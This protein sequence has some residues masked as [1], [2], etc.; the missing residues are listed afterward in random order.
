VFG[1]P[2]FGKGLVQTVYPL[3]EGTGLALTTALYY[4]PSGRSIQKP[5]DA[6]Q[7]ELAATT[8]HPNGSKEFRTDKGRPVLGG[9]GIQ[10]D[11]VVYPPQMNRL[12]TVLE[13]T[14]S[15]TSFA[16]EYL[17]QHKVTDEFEVTPQVIDEFQLW[18]SERAIQ[19]GVGEWSAEREFVENR[20]KTEIFNQ[21]LGVEKGD[22]VEA[23]RDPVIR[24][25]VEALGG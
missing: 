10:P 12:R 22:Q 7:F 2:S 21:A 9:G 11:V 23:E 5:L 15:F 25:A 16:T 18:L 4:T 19:P 1:V 8:A 13:A 20:L 17:S 3:N 14:G 6:A 24:K